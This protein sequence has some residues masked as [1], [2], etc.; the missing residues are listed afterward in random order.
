MTEAAGFGG[1]R[2][3]GRGPGAYQPILGVT[4]LTFDYVSEGGPTSYGVLK[5]VYATDAAVLPDGRLLISYAKDVNQDYGLYTI[6]P[7][8]SDLTLL[9]DN[10]DTS[11]LRTKVV[12]ARAAADYCRQCHPGG[13]PLPTG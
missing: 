1:L 12:A 4:K 11:E 3:Y 8:G 7:D 9:Y 5:G 13:Q 10:P 2:R 6:N